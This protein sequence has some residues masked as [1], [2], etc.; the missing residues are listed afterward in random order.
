[1]FYGLL[2]PEIEA[3]GADVR[4]RSVT[5]WETDRTCATYPGEAR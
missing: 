2:K 3:S 1:V 5:V 4:L